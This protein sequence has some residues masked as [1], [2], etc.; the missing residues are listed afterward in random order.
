VFAYRL[1]VRSTDTAENVG[2]FAL[3]G[4]LPRFDIRG[5]L[6]VRAARYVEE[7]L[8]PF[9]E[10]FEGAALNSGEVSEE[11]V[12]AV[13]RREPQPQEQV[14]IEGVGGATLPRP[15]YKSSPRIP[16][17]AGVPKAPDRVYSKPATSAG[18]W[19]LC[20]LRVIASSFQ[21]QPP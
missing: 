13:A 21:I 7:Y 16:K 19:F 11:V 15:S 3:L 14:V 9:L 4:E 18:K 10:R 20:P 2:G 6:A 8:L 1:T 17:S 5:L 12:V